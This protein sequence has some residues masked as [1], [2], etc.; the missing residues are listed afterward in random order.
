MTTPLL[1]VVGL[2]CLAVALWLTS[3]PGPRDP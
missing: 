1:I 2:I 3:R